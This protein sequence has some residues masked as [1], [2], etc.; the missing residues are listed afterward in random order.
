MHQNNQQKQPLQYM[1]F[2]SSQH[3]QTDDNQAKSM[4]IYF[5]TTKLNKDLYIYEKDRRKERKIFDW[6]SD[7]IKKSSSK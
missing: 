1:F 6:T 4:R 2:F 7:V 5:S 3:D